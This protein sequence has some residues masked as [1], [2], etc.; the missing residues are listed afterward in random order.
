MKNQAVYL[1]HFSKPLS[2]ARHYAGYVNAKKRGLGI[3]DAVAARLAEHRNGTGARICQLQSSE[4]LNCNWSDI[5][6][7]REESLNVA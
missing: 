3:D 2:H 1:I 4:E 6:Q 5:G 7:T